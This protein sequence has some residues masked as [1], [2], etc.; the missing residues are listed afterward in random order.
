MWF[1]FLINSFYGYY[2]WTLDSKNERDWVILKN[3]R[4]RNE[5]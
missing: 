5:K 4:K 3:W 2:K 1:G